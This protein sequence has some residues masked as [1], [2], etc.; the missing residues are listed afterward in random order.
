MNIHWTLLDP[1]A[2]SHDN[3][4]ITQWPNK[5]ITS[6]SFLLHLYR[7]DGELKILKY[8]TYFHTHPSL[9]HQVPSREDIW[10]KVIINIIIIGIKT[11]TKL[12]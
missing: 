7:D 3:S 8:T 1:L 5:L 10:Q 4:E 2:I 9:D 12:T 6:Q 11:F